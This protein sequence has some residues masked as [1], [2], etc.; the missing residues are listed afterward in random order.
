MSLFEDAPTPD[1][2]K[3]FRMA[4]RYLGIRPRSIQEMTRYLEKKNQ[5]RKIISKVI[6][7]LKQ[8]RYLD[9]ENF[10]RLFIENRKTR[11]P[12]SGFALTCELKQKGISHHLIADLLNDYDDH[13][14]ACRAIAAKFRQW[15]H[16]EPDVRRHKAFSYLKYRG[17]G[18]EIS[19]Y[20]WETVE[21][22]NDLNDGSTR[23]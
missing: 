10:A 5:D 12:K 17:F 15:H 2:E 4:V 13:V 19:Q 21:K 23:F 18:Y 3:A 11:N 1:M 8:Y 16:L 14:M 6:E 20:A 22:R 7:R 9:D